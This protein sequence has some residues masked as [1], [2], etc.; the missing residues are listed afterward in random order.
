MAANFATLTD[1][2]E[3]CF[4]GLDAA[5]ETPSSILCGDRRLT[6][7]GA[8]ARPG[9]LILISANKLEFPRKPNPQGG[10]LL[11]GDG[12]IH[13][14][15]PQQLNAALGGALTPTTPTIRLLIP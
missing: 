11:F 12:S 5:E 9:L 4:T 8:K 13:R 10:N 15:N 1:V 2:H 14:V 6:V 3:S 7:N